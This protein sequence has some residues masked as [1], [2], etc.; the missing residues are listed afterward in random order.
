[1]MHALTRTREGDAI[2]SGLDAVVAGVVDARRRAAQ[3]QAAEARFLAD[4]VGLV[5]ERTA[6]LRQE[7]QHRGGSVRSSDADLP[8]RE[9]ALELAMALRVSDRGVQRRM[10]EA[11]LLTT[12]FPRT[13][14]VW[15]GGEID[16]AHAWAISRTG[17]LLT[18]EADRSRYETLALEAARSE[19]PARMSAAAKAIAA[20]IDPAAFTEAAQRAYDERSVRLFPLEDGMARLIADLPAPLAHAIHDTLTAQGRA[21]LDQPDEGIDGEADATEAATLTG[22][23]TLITGPARAT[24]VTCTTTPTATTAVKDSRTLAQVRADILTDLLLTATPSTRATG[25]GV[26]A[27]TAQIQVTIPALTLAG[28]P[29]GG[30]AILTGYG[31]IDPGLARRLAA[32]APGWD[33]V[34]TDPTTGIPVAVDRYRPSAELRRYLAA[35]DERCRTPGCTRPAHRC[36]R[37]HTTAAA[38]GGP[39]APDNL[40]HLCRR[41]HTVKHH[42]AWRVRHLGHGTLQWTSPTGRHYED[43]PPSLVRFVPEPAT[44]ADPPPF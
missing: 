36:D 16:A 22:A 14:E 23:D 31:P 9:V 20:T 10:S 8:L 35:R 25:A 2:W 27:V 17:T 30:P 41:H 18:S 15:A 7:A 24:D 5:A 26:E 6:L 1:M 37:D 11:Y 43:H 33:R 39:T 13:L 19:S 28:D 34:F 42:T 29:D 3:A 21:I 12:L 32:L 38:E 4:A 40:A 44:P